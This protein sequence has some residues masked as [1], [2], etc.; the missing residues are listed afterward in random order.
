MNFFVYPSKDTTISK[1]IN[2][3]ELSFGTSEI[4]EIKNSFSEGSGHSLSR[5]LM[6]FDMPL[7]KDNYV[8]YNKDL[9]IFLELK[10]TESEDVSSDI[11]LQVFPL[12]ESWL[13]GIG[14]GFDVDPVYG[15]ANWIYRNHED[16]WTNSVV[17]GGPSNYETI[18]E[19]SSET[20]HSIDSNFIF[21]HKTSDIS[22]DITPIAMRWILGDIPN[23]GLV[24]KLK[25]ESTNAPEVGS[26]KFYSKDT[27]TIYSPFLRFSYVDSVNLLEPQQPNESMINTI[28]GTLSGT[29]GY[30]KPNTD[31]LDYEIVPLE[32]IL[33]SNFDT[34]KLIDSSC[35]VIEQKN[36]TQQTTNL[37]KISGNIISKIKTINK[38][39]KNSEILRIDVGVRSKN[40]MKT[41]LKKAVYGGSHYT[42]YDMFYSLKDAET[43]ETI[44]DFNKYS[45]ISTD[46]NGHFFN[47]NFGCLSV[48]RYFRFSI[49]IKNEYGESIHEDTRTFTVEV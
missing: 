45:K 27:N 46:E 8:K 34:T 12:T 41:I 42:D 7:N 43:N 47:F 2:E 26:I 29:L 10:I 24:I 20:I 18:K 1:N 13:E 25:D 23:N 31:L 35:E 17:N 49:L 15:P 21:S 36:F 48:G 28:S 14:R 16:K 5:I 6:E 37:Q 9:K 38:K 4:L 44:I 33:N 30:E 22:V 40:P 39:Y 3:R 11:Q 32:T 19:C